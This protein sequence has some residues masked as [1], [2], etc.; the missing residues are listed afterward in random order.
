MSAILAPIVSAA[1]K[2]PTNPKKFFSSELISE[3]G[4]LEGR[5]QPTF[6]T[7]GESCITNLFFGFFF[8]GTRNNYR[9]AEA[10]KDHSNV[11]RLYDCFPG[12]SVP[13]VLP[14]YTD[15]Q[16]RSEQYTHFFKVYI[17]GVASPFPN[18]GDSGQ[19][20]DATAGAAGGRL[21]ERRIIWALAQAMNNVHRYFL[22]APLLTS[23]DL[24]RLFRNTSLTRVARAAMDSQSAAQMPERTQYRVGRTREEFKAALSRLHAA[25]APHWAD[26][27]TGKPRKIDPGTVKTIYISTFGFSR[28][29]T[30][31]RVFTNW[32]QSLC[33]LDAE[34][35]G[36]PGEMSLGGFHVEFDFLGLF[37]TVASV[38]LANSTNWWDG[39]AAWADA[40]D[41]LRVPSGLK[42]LHLVA[43]HELRRSFPVDSIAVNGVLSPGHEEIVLPGVHSDVGCGYCPCEQGK[44]SDANG[45]DMLSRIPLLMMYKSARINGAPLK[46]ELASETVKGRFALSNRTIETF[47]AYI[48]TCKETSGPIHRIMREQARKQM[49]WRLA[50]RVSGPTPVHKIPGFARA[51]T[52]H[53]N[54]IYSAAL[55]FDEEIA[56]FEDWLWKRGDFFMPANQPPGF[57]NNRD[58]EWEE[59]ATWWRKW[60]KP[61]VE[62]LRFFDDYVHDSRASF[63]CLGDADNERELKML[64]NK[65]VQL[66]HQRLPVLAG[67]ADY[68]Q[69]SS[70]LT[71]EQERAADEYARTGKIPR[72]V[73]G[74]RE[75]F[76]GVEAGYLR[77]RKVYG[78]SDGVLLS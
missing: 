50:R 43:A 76:R 61:S 36:R 72:M 62:V 12:L 49:E 40:E 56:R 8:D 6:G 46:L 34:L 58:A 20:G 45:D 63:K 13:G 33:R 64:L 69:P 27:R 30:E 31:A 3:L 47:N 74:G 57:N 55:E 67:K 16:Y 73:N 68:A 38:G 11:A 1:F 70:A 23:S 25:L 42:C 78:G 26:P 18:I 15:W 9:Q 51:S 39:H 71:Q 35:R 4:A 54:D 24:D 65:W 28:G 77:Y 19:G 17:P 75:P 2:F 52:L 14:S 29:A 59:I 5:E 10:T 32:L 48:A 37:D 41:S 21:G 7:P 22:K 53:Q 44:G 60:K 66:R